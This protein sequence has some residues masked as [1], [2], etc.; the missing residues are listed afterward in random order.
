MA[1]WD[2][3]KR[4]CGHLWISALALALAAGSPVWAGDVLKGI[5]KKDVMAVGVN[6]GLPGFAMRNAQGEWTGFDVDIARG[7]AAAVL[8][9][10][11]KIKWV[12]VDARNRFEALQRGEIELLSRNTTFTFTRDV[13]MGLSQTAIVFFDGQAFMVPTRA[14]LRSAAQ[15]RGKAVCVQAGT[16]SLKN[17][18]D[19][20]RAQQLKIK[21]MAFDSLGTTQAAYLAGR[22]AAFTADSSA[23]AS[24]RA[25]QT[26]RPEEHSILPELISKEPQG[27]MVKRGDEEFAA[28]VRW[29]LYGLMEAEEYG[30][31]QSNVE[32]LRQNS[33]DPTVM[34]LLG[35]S[36]GYGRQLGLDDEWLFRALKAVGNYGEIFARH[37]G[38]QTPLGLSRGRNQ[39]WMSGGLVY[40]PPF[41]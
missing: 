17:L 20:S 1:P 41:R 40:S 34:R 13:G 9:S 15:L 7:V 28:I 8:G 10:A 2:R 25:T 11:D 22:C 6:P 37:V 29:V 18:E 4:W 36:D 35:R 26:P 23:L 3:C 38:P 14:G 16:T 31:R 30:V 19:Y 12:P 21:P 5:Q 39:S 27:P 33:S 32:Q 24:V